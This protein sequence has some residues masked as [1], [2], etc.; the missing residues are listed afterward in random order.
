MRARI[1]RLLVLTLGWSLVLLVI[2]GLVLP[3]LQGLMLILLGLIILSSE[4]QWARRLLAKLEARFPKIRLGSAHG[5]RQC[6]SMAETPLFSA[7]QRLQARMRSGLRQN[8]EA[9]E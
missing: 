3:F 8:Q 4:Y 2:A 9:A 7:R 6:K 5:D 1:R